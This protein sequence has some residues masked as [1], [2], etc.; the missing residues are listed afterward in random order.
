[1]NERIK[2]DKVNIINLEDNNNG[3]NETN[4]CIELNPILML[5]LSLEYCAIKKFHGRLDYEMQKLFNEAYDLAHDSKYRDKL[6]PI[7]RQIINTVKQ[8]GS[9]KDHKIEHEE[10]EE[11]PC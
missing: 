9:F 6:I 4:D 7:L 1:M 3:I 8:A 11:S 5:I 2:D 10:E